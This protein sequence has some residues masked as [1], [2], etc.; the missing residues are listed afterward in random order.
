MIKQIKLGFFA[1]LLFSSFSIKKNRSGC[2]NIPQFTIERIEGD[3]IN[4]S[5][6]ANK[7]IL[8]V[9]LPTQQTTIATTML[10]SLDSLAIS[11][12]NDLVVI[13]VPSFE[14]GYTSSGKEDLKQ[15][16][17]S[18]L[19][20]GVIISTGLYTRKSSG[21]LQHPLFKWLTNSSEN[22]VFNQDVSGPWFKFFLNSNGELYGLL[23]PQTSFGSVSVSR[24]LTIQ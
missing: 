21:S 3:S 2:I 7:K 1:I 11:N 4:F 23:S 20:S 12:S 16:Y 6:W 19:S 18:K 10:G 15:W 22:E 8:I 24:I 9:T 5:L 14:D 17:K 13:A